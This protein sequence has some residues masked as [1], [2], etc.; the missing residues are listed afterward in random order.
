MNSTQ[1]IPKRPQTSRQAKRAY[2]KQKGPR[3]SETE[4]RRLARADELDQ[5]AKKIRDQEKARKASAKKRAEKQAADREKRKQL[6][7]APAD[8]ISPSQKRL[9]D[10]LRPKHAGKENVRQDVY[11]RQEAN[12]LAKEGVLEG[13]ESAC[14]LIRDLQGNVKASEDAASGEYKG[15]PSQG[16]FDPQRNTRTNQR[17]GPGLE[18]TREIRSS[19]KVYLPRVP[20]ISPLKGKLELPRVLDFASDEDASAQ[21]PDNKTKNN[22]NLMPPPPPKKAIPTCDEVD[23]TQFLDTNTQIEREVLLSPSDNSMPTCN[24]DDW[25]CFLESNSQIEREL[26]AS[27]NTDS[28]RLDGKDEQ[29]PSG[30]GTAGS[31]SKHKNPTTPTKS[32]DHHSDKT[33]KCSRSSSVDDFLC[34]ISTQELNDFG[35]S[36][37]SA[38][39]LA[40][41]KKSCSVPEMQHLQSDLDISG[42]ETAAGDYGLTDLTEQDWAEIDADDLS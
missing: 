30:N 25:T 8:K 16:G 28:R 26:Q 14:E 15:L 22:R 39:R 18:M 20:I 40:D 2:S 11:E 29:E 12:D 41:N 21:L 42:L 5:R 7:D 1:P 3:I 37:V 35:S 38:C 10:F 4:K 13:Q 23:W 27:P 32:R 36:P 24:E 9:G 33:S 31:T 6:G 19:A 17:V 34:N